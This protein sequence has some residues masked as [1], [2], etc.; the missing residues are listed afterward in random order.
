MR[1]RLHGGLLLVL[2]LTDTAVVQS[3]GFTYTTNS[4][5]I[6]ITGSSC[7]MVACLVGAVSIP[8]VINGLPVVGIGDDAFFPDYGLTQVTLPDT[9][10]LIGNGAFWGC[11]GLTNIVIPPG[12]TKIGLGA[13]SQCSSLV[14]VTIPNGVQ[15]IEPSTFFE[16][17]SLTNITIPSGIVSIGVSAFDSCGRLSNVT[18]PSSLTNIDNDAF[19][20]CSN[21]TSIFFKGNAPTLG[22]AVFQ[23]D[24]IATVYYLPA[25]KG[26]GPTFGGIP[27]KLWN[28][29]VLTQDA[30]FGVQHNHFGFNITGTPDIPL[31]VEAS[32]NAAAGFWVSL[33][34]STLTNGLIYFNDTK[35]NYASRFYRIRSP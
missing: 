34:S 1:V 27:T 15:N 30:S 9:I 7:G 8:S 10:T 33:Q 20:M 19:F 26:W 32:T 6:T 28:P 11:S 29:Q 16:C 22:G 17:F 31:V 35:T 25:T 23:Y 21:L 5:T 4:G 3:Q 14:S 18:I 2:L 13:F 24:S 12:V